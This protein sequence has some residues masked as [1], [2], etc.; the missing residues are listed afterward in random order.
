[1]CN[2]FVGSWKL[3][4]SENFDDYMKELGEIYLDL[5][6]KMLQII[7]CWF[8]IRVLQLDHEMFNLILFKINIR[9]H[10]DF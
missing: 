3:I 10:E 7:R 1:M 5:I 4:S 8:L 2:K 9:K 6:F